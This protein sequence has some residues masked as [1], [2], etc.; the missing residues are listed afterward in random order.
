MP[1]RTILPT[2]AVLVPEQ[3]ERVFKGVIYD[4]YQWK[5]P[6]YDG[7]VGVF[8][9]L[10]RPDTVEVIVVRENKILVQYQEQ[11]HLGRFTSF[12]GGR[13]D[14]EGDTE[15]DAVKRELREETG[16]ICDNWKLI[17][18]VQPHLKI[19]QFIYT[20]VA[21]N[22][23]EHVPQELDNG[24]KIENKWVTLE[25]FNEILKTTR[26]RTRA[27]KF[28]DGISDITAILNLPEFQTQNSTNS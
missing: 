1:L 13:H 18:V 15:L 27:K 16:Y 19:E 4:V 20:F 2:N 10:K 14:C 7:S 24:E 23:V 26:F 17:D 5:E 28:L 11:P 3:A 22:I 8:E 6:M 12:P 21:A 9:M 25:E